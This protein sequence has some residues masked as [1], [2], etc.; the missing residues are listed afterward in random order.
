MM[1][2]SRAL[3]ALSKASFLQNEELMP[4]K[5][6]TGVSSFCLFS[7]YGDFIY[8]QIFLFLILADF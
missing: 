6:K 3:E 2:N 8:W 1:T 5:I 4:H 7:K